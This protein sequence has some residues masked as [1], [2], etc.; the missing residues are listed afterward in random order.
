M[1]SE[2]TKWSVVA[3]NARGDTSELADLQRRLSDGYFSLKR[4]MVNIPPPGPPS[5]LDE[6]RA[7]GFVGLVHTGVGTI[8]EAVA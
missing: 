1:L 7:V 3:Q 2:D 5:D 8:A 4:A 6:A